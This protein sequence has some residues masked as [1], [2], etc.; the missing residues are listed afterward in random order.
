M[1]RFKSQRISNEIV[2]LALDLLIF[3]S[4]C[5]L[6]VKALSLRQKVLT[7][8]KSIITICA[9]EPDYRKI[10]LSYL[11]FFEEAQ[12]E[13]YKIGFASQQMAFKIIFHFFKTNTSYANIWLQQQKLYRFRIID[14][15][16]ISNDSL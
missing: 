9:S 15:S 1:L 2:K 7:W 13:R 8:V 10:S 12:H 4:K 5:I 11:C 16:S 14:I 6:F 3:A